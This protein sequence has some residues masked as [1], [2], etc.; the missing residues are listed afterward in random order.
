M[1]KKLFNVLLAERSF[2]DNAKKVFKGI[3]AV[4]DFKNQKH[5][6]S[7]LKYADAV[8]TGLEVTFDK[9]TLDRAP[10]LT[11]IGSRTTQLRHI[12]LK[13]CARRGIKIV[14]IKAGSSVLQNTPSTAEETIAL[15]F[16]L[17]RNIPWAFDSIKKRQWRRSEYGGHELSHKTVGLIGF[18]RLGRMVSRYVRPFGVATLAY[19]PYVGADVMKKFGVAKVPLKE[20][21]KRSDIVSI[22][23]VY[24]DATRGMIAKD[25]FKLMKPTAALVNTARGEITNE[26]DLLTALTRK[27]IAGAAVDT[28]AG[29]TPSGSHLRGNALVDYAAKHQNLIIL[30]H[31]GGAT[32]EAT[33]RTQVYISKLIRD[34]LKKMGTA[35]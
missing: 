17:L 12:D 20:L 5:F 14:N 6:L 25:H 29:E 9:A 13:E 4:S 3:A 16:A 33:E 31:L 10:R 24:N 7:A 11:L 2:S 22:H 28:L 32:R 8:I 18:G 21:L 34:E 26:K 30:P 19:D 15:I 23:A 27:W 1:A 35:K